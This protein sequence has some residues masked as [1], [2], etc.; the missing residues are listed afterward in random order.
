MRREGGQALVF[1]L[2]IAGALAAA[3]LA[4]FHAG[5]L[6]NGKQRLLNAA[7]AAAW[8]AAA[9]QARTLNLE[10]YINRSIVANEVA[11]AQSVS[12][13]S[14]SAYMRRTIDRVDNVTRWL[15]WLGQATRVLERAW[16]GIDRGLQPALQGAE[17]VLA[18]SQQALAGAQA[19]VHAG[20]FAAA[21]DLATRTVLANDPG[22]RLAPA[23]AALFAA[24]AI[25]WQ[26]FT[27]LYSGNDRL[28]LQRVVEASLDR[29]TTDRGFDLSPPL[30]G[31]LV[32][33]RKRG[34]TD[35]LAYDTWRGMDTLA[36][37]LRS[38]G[39]FGSMRE[40]ISVGWG[41]AENGRWGA[42]DGWHGG[43]WRINPRTSRLARRDAS[44]SRSHRGLPAV[45]DISEPQRRDDRTLDIVIALE[46]AE[47]RT[48]ADPTRSGARLW[49]SDGALLSLPESLPRA[50]LQAIGAAQ[51][52]FS[53]PQPRADGS[54][55][56]PSLFNPY[57][58][59][60]LAPVSLRDR[61]IVAAANG[62]ADPF[63][64]LP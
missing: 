10:A 7:D 21:H 5:Q 50:R 62:I 36:I 46:G 28:R 11:I 33:I 45:R 1:V 57:W 12:L 38:G 63:A 47:L 56:L 6:V 51:V 60:R 4:T 31:Q 27:T 3:M 59:A 19:I 17:A 35:L 53:R 18:F 8:S 24:R 26:R 23:S 16:A 39:L 20:G 40:R 54:R 43:T 13:R 42:S 22:A 25:A 52:Y 55:E 9:W 44:V 14:W 2:G 41:A 49:S 58:Q 48:L 61:A 32:R 29:F 30:L 15:P 64:V 34:G 37:H